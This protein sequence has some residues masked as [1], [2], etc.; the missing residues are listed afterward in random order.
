MFAPLNIDCMCLLVAPLCTPNNEN[1][2]IG[3]TKV[4][5]SS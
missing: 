5:L 3:M 1:W 4:F 2:T